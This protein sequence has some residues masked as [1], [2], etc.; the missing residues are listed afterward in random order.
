MGNT[1]WTGARLIDVLNYCGANLKLDDIKHIQFEG[2]DLDATASPYGASVPADIALDPK[3]E[4]LLAYEMNGQDLPADHGYPVRL[5]APGIVGARNVKWLG[6]IVLADHECK[7]HW[8]QNDYKSFPSNKESATAEDWAQAQA[9]QAM[10]VQSAIC[11]PKVGDKVKLCWKQIGERISPV[12]EA[13]GYAW[14]GGGRKINRVDVSIDGG[15]NWYQA[16]LEQEI[17]AKDKPTHTY[18]WSLW[19]VLLN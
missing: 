2:L 6:R 17:G 3:S 13:Q 12:I 8:Q 10:P 19:K 7:S 9:I 5:I 15:K 4:F 16:T 1:R 11:V 18:S 14:S